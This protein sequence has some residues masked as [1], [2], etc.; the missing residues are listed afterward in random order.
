MVH[1]G[2][3]GLYVQSDCAAGTILKRTPIEHITLEES[4]RKDKDK[5]FNCFWK[6]DAQ[7]QKKPHK[8][9]YVW[10]YYTFNM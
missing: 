9:T 7:T 6:S 1:P 10:F 3:A 4:G 8:A 2:G 5:M